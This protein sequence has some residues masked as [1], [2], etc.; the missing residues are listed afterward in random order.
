[1]SDL[2]NISID[3]EPQTWQQM[4]EREKAERLRLE[5]YTLMLSD[6]DRNEHGRHEGDGDTY[7]PSGRSHGNPHLKTGDVVGYSIHGSWKYVVPEPR[8]RGKL[9]AWRVPRD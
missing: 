7:D 6:L 3:G 8:Q 9:D 1:M 5:G 2:S 4:Y